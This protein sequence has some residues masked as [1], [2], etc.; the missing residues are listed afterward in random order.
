MTLS[1]QVFLPVACLFALLIYSKFATR[2]V[3]AL[4]RFADTVLLQYKM[5]KRV[6]NIDSGQVNSKYAH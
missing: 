5:D 1:H 2:K 6:Q 4:E 3:S